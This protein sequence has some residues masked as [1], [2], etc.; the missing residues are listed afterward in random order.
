MANQHHVDTGFLF[1]RTHGDA[2]KALQELRYEQE[3]LL[4][5]L[6]SYCIVVCMETNHKREEWFSFVV[7]LDSRILRRS[8]NST[9]RSSNDSADPTASEVI[10]NFLDYAVGC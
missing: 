7:F 1:C 9:G 6:G 4:N 2:N 10:L 3:S 8:S 5:S